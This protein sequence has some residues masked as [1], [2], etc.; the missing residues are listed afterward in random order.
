MVPSL[1]ADFT[2]HVVVLND[3]ESLAMP[4]PGTHR[5]RTQFVFSSVCADMKRRDASS[6]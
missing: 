5:L 1:N 4:G 2:Y 6:S 3:A